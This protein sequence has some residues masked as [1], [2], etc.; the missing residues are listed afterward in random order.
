MIPLLILVALGGLMQ[1]ARS[2]SIVG[3][4]SGTEL[5]FGYLLL[6]AYFT[7]KLIGRFS[8]PKLTGYLIAGV[9]SGPFVLKLVTSDMAVSLKVVNGVATSILGLSAGAELDLKEIKPMMRT[10]RSTTMY[11][12][13]GSM[14]VLTG[15]VFLLRPIIPLFDGM[16]LEHAIAIAALI[17]V[18]LS[19]QSPAVVMALISETKS[20]GPL[21]RLSL[22][23]VV[24]SDLVVI[25]FYSIAAAVAGAV[26]GGEI[27]VLGTA[28]EVAWELLGS[29]AFGIAIGMLIGQFIRAVHNGASMFALLIC[30]VVAEI[31]SR[32]HLDPLVVMIAAG[33]WLQNFSRAD[34]SVLLHKFEAAELPVFLVFFAL[35]GTK[36]DLGQLWS[37]ILPVIAIASLRGIW[38]YMGSKI[39]CKRT[40]AA[41]LVT[42]YAWT[43]LVP[44][45]GLSLAL[46]TVIS[47]KFPGWG[48]PA[49][50]LLLS[51][52]GV[53]QILA[54][55]FLR[56][57]LLRSGEA[58]HKKS[59]D[60]A[61]EHD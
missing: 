51:V 43:G 22:A 47:S 16:P 50:I 2:F 36:L 45:A 33:I 4:F 39:A 5:A 21:S 58:G 55:V 42:K 53:N 40:E 14:V 27:D 29:I 15:V 61:S 60:F 54:P 19:A 49:G 9:V 59:V 18:A 34:A 12:V 56:I 26:V 25:L 1:A 20:D 38:M 10:I 3:A 6:A 24:V 57:A 7:A 35:A 8:L 41:P 31:G 17:G 28:L 52:V 32:V 11:A 48:P 30:I 23:T 46:V 44:Q 37:T 13:I